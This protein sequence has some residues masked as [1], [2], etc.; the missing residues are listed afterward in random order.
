MTTETMFDPKKDLTAKAWYAFAYALALTSEEGSRLREQFK[1]A[2][3]MLDKN[4]IS[5]AD[6][7]RDLHEGLKE[8]ME[9]GL[10]ECER[11]GE[12]DYVP[13]VVHGERVVG[14]GILGL[15]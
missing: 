6:R 10:I 5:A 11:D 7:R 3:Q 8:L 9:V 12:G 15:A 13:R 1:A 14:G 2:N 4:G